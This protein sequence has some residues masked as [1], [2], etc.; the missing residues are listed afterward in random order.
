MS[1]VALTFPNW[2]AIT[3]SAI[4]ILANLAGAW[5]I[6]LTVAP[7]YTAPTHD[8]RWIYLSPIF[9]IGL[10][11]PFL[12][13]PLAYALC[14]GVLAW[15]A[16]AIMIDSATHKLPNLLTVGTSVAAVLGSILLAIY[17]WDGTIFFSSLLI[18]AFATIVLVMM[19]QMGFGLG[20]GDVKLFPALVM[21]ASSTGTALTFFLALAIFPGFYALALLMLGNDRHKRIAYGPWMALALCLALWIN[22]F[23]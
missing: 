18:A 5:L 8:R 7:A 22:A 17:H 23:I 15:L 3:L 21:C 16:P 19:Y 9:S 20:A 4:F 6:T 10:A 14:V 1:D 2:L 12:Y 13:D 11:A